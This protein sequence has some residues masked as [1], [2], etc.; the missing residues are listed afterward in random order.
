MISGEQADLLLGKD[1]I[2]A[3]SGD[4]VGEVL[5]VYLDAETGLPEWVMTRTGLLGTNPRF[6]PLVEAQLEDRGVVVPYDK[7]AV[8]NAPEMGES[9]ALPSPEQ[10]VRLTS[11]TGW[12]L[13]PPWPG[14][15]ADCVSTSP[16]R[17]ASPGCPDQPRRC[18]VP[19]LPQ[20]QGRGGRHAITT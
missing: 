5:H 20:R 1:L 12:A 10:E 19:A 6:V 3:G 8:K 2:H 14:R 7:D 17:A 18:G 4:K 11:T 9:S 16:G 13:G 15:A